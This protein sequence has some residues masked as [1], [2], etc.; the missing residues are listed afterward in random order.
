MCR[1]PKFSTMLSVVEEGLDR[2]RIPLTIEVVY[3]RH[4]D[5]WEKRTTHFQRTPAMAHDKIQ[6]VTAIRLGAWEDSIRP[7]TEYILS[8]RKRTFNI[9]NPSRIAI[10][11]P[12]FDCDL[13]RAGI[14]PSPYAKPY[15][16]QRQE[17]RSLEGI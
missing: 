2:G 9:D 7:Y 17:W 14:H 4:K 5:T 12:L 1:V 10:G 8:F 16:A 11:Q 13:H 6:V 15:H 3:R